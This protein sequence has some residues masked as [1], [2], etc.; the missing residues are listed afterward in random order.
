MKCSELADAVSALLQAPAP[1]L[2]RC[3]PRGPGRPE[4]GAAPET[5]PMRRTLLAVAVAASLLTPLWDLLSPIWDGSENTDEG[6]G[7]DPSGHCLPTPRVDEGCVWDPD[8][9]CQ[10]APQTDAGCIWD[11]DGRC[12]PVPQTDAGCIWDP[13]GS[14]C[15]S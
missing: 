8:G 6:C 11:P 14:P 10:P 1:I 5:L 4:A 12:Q 13:Y 15:R 7:W 3:G 2:G 9:R